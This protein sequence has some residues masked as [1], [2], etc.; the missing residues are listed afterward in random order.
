M[1]RE[2]FEMVKS[3]LT[4]HRYYANE[5]DYSLSISEGTIGDY[6]YYRIVCYPNGPAQSFHSGFASF[7]VQVAEVCC[8]SCSFRAVNDTCICVFY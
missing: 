2:T 4:T 1:K 3:V 8:C 5:T 6:E 7:F